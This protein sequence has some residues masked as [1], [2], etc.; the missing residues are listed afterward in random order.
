M[1]E[2][3]ADGGG[4]L[5]QLGESPSTR[6][7]RAITRSC[8]VAGISRAKSARIPAG[9]GADSLER[10]GL[11]DQL[12]EFLDEERD[13]AGSIAELIDQRGWQRRLDPPLE[14]RRHFLAGQRRQRQRGLVGAGR[15]R[16]LEIGAEGQQREDGI[17]LAGEHELLQELERRGIDPLQVLDD[18]QHGS[19]GGVRAQPVTDGRQRGL[20]LPGGD[21]DR[22]VAGAE[23]QGQQRG[24][25]RHGFVVRQA[26]PFEMPDQPIE[27]AL[28]GLDVEC[29]GQ[30]LEEVD[31]R[32]Q[33]AV[34]TLRRAPPL[35]DG[36]LGGCFFGRRCGM[37]TGRRGA[38]ARC[39]RRALA[40][41]AS[42]CRPAVIC[43]GR[44]RP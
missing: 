16:R 4:Q 3:A 20:S 42:A 40:G 9:V 38:R 28:R 19:V 1:T 24:E 12:R 6:P 21:S 41:A 7:S 18:E 2:L 14:H 37:P 34:L 27:S 26:E 36:P 22:L 29:V 23:R 31:D 43:R 5:R 17:P 8:S 33:A 30:P 10:P 44:L 25:Q 35:D 11:S 32:I 15:P 39:R 13:A